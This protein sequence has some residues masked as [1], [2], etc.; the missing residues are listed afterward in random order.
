[1][2]TDLP[3]PTHT[4]KKS[5]A[6]RVRVKLDSCIAP[7]SL[8]GQHMQGLCETRSCWQEVYG[9]RFIAN[10]DASSLYPFPHML[11]TP[12]PSESLK[13]PPFHRFNL[14]SSQHPAIS[15]PSPPAHSQRLSQ[16]QCQ[17]QGPVSS[18]QRKT[19]CN[20]GLTLAH[21]SLKVM[22]RAT[23]AQLQASN[24]GPSVLILVCL[25]QCTL[26]LTARGLDFG[27]PTHHHHHPSAASVDHPQ[28][29][30]C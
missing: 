28:P 17:R 18:L 24:T 20:C 5:A 22:S 13:S 8:A 9:R 12:S 21:G 2:D 11:R 29:H 19:H 6:L 16:H 7:R 30:S 3:F 14:A 23:L 25:C 15:P 10:S 4:T 26:S 1:M 27:R